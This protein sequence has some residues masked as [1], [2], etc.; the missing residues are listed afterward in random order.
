LIDAECKDE[1]L[2]NGARAFKIIMGNNPQCCSDV[3]YQVD[4]EPW[5]YA[6]SFSSTNLNK[7]NYGEL[8]YWTRSGASYV[9]NWPLKN[10]TSGPSS[11]YG[12]YDQNG[13]LPEA[14]ESMGTRTF[15]GLSYPGVVYRGFG[16]G[17]S[18]A[19]EVPPGT[20]PFSKNDANYTRSVGMLNISQPFYY[21]SDPSQATSESIGGAIRVGSYTNPLNLPG[22]VSVGDPNNPA[23]PQTG[24][25]SVSNVF[26]LN[27]FKVSWPE[28]ISFLNATDRDMASNICAWNGSASI[29][30]N[31]HFRD[32]FISTTINDP[33]IYRGYYNQYALSYPALDQC[34]AVHQI[35]P[36]IARAYCNWL[37][38]RVDDPN[39][40]NWR[41][42]AYN[43]DISVI[44]NIC[45]T[46]VGSA[47]NPGAR[48]WLPTE[49]EWYKAAY[50]TPNKNNSGPGYWNYAT[51]YDLQPDPVCSTSDGVGLKYAPAVPDPGQR[52][53]C[54]ECNNQDLVVYAQ[55]PAN[56]SNICFKSACG[57]D[58][59]SNVVCE[60]A[61]PTIPP[62]PPPPQPPCIQTVDLSGYTIDITYED[63]FGD[64]PCSGGHTC[65]RATFDF[66]INDTYIGTAFLDNIGGPN[67]KGPYTTDFN[68]RFDRKS[69][70][71]VPQGITTDENGK[72]SFRLECKYT[73]GCHMGIAWIRIY[74]LTN[75][76]VLDTCIMNDI[77]VILR[78]CTTTTTE[79][80][81][82]TVEPTTT[83]VVPTTTTVEPTTTTVVPTTTTVEPTTTTVVPTTTVA[84]TTTTVVPTTTTVVPTTTTV[85]PTTTT[86]VPTTTVAPTTT[87][88]VPT[89]T[90]VVPTTT[91]VVPTTTTAVPTTTTTIAPTTTPSP[92]ALLQKASTGV[93]NTSAGSGTSSSPLIWNGLVENNGTYLM[94]TSLTAGILSLT[95]TVRSG[96]GDFGCDIIQVTKNNTLAWDPSF[97]TGATLSRS[98]TFSVATNDIIRLYILNE[99]GAR[100]QSFSA[101]I[102]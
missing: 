80:T 65:N 84:P 7:A 9:F 72:Y 21:Y 99:W 45:R 42:G 85:E 20:P 11:Y 53:K 70:M 101:N 15:N 63:N 93:F 38:N 60:A 86:V 46:I 35:G 82:T 96:C 8:G 32:L 48:Y 100:V 62:P 1:I 95:M 68:K 90:T 57:T 87:T 30:S 25:G 74:D 79:P 34:R 83:T 39:T 29:T 37:H 3:L 16:A 56:Y 52:G 2:S 61:C 64:S 55:L 102:Q 27:K 73:T 40:S 22:F 66:K 88:V 4:N 17:A 50:Y 98:T 10:G 13:G 67:D 97:P 14:T 69:T 91:T 41:T 28:F 76:K 44:N 89:T 49:D 58:L 31:D 47:R 54:K 18:I 75:T 78:E 26:L 5:T 81:T 43:I 19:P 71:I 92:S 51:Q 59:E 33:T 77:S 24:Y 23:D 36:I 12:T 94:F 6:I